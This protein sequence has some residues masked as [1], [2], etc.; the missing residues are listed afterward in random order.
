MLRARTMIPWSLLLAGCA[1]AVIVKLP[2][3]GQVPQKAAD[4]KRDVVVNAQN[5]GADA[6]IKKIEDFVSKKP[7]EPGPI[8]D[9]LRGLLLARRD[10]AMR[11]AKAL[12]AYYAEGRIDV[13]KYLGGIYGV[14]D[15][16]RELTDNPAEHV[17]ILELRLT[18]A[19]DVE[20]REKGEVVV[21]RGTEADVEE[22]VCSRLAV[23]IDLL[24]TKRKLVKK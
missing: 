4:G 1:L 14:L 24:R 18:L 23:E 6:F 19:K 20:D 13:G 3:A 10:A 15:A 16:Q 9:E 7:V 2:A 11:R 8:D 22:A 5:D 17:P 12:R 21:G